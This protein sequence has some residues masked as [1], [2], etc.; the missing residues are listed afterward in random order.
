MVSKISSH[1]YRPMTMDVW[2]QRTSGYGSRWS[3]V[4]LPGSRAWWGVSSHNVAGDPGL[5]NVRVTLLATVCV[6]AAALGL[7]VAAAALSVRR[8]A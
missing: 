5:T 3:F 7:T 1:T 2:P 6:A 4:D 8:R